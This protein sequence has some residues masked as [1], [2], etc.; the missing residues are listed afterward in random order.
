M[1]VSWGRTV[2]KN[3]GQYY[4]FA[5]SRPHTYAMP[6]YFFYYRIQG[7][8]NYRAIAGTYKRKKLVLHMMVCVKSASLNSYLLNAKIYTETV[9][10]LLFK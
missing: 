4:W 6:Q 10:A 2:E 8:N 9:R 1:A 7:A 5:G 3:L